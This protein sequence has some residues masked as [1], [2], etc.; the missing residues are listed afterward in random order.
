[1]IKSFRHK[2]LEEFFRNG[3]KKGI[4]PDHSSKLSRLLDRLDASLTVKDMAL[5]GFKLH[6]LSGK[7]KNI[8]S[9]WVNGNWRV[10]FYFEEGD[11]FIVDY[12]DY[13]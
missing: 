10:T 3:N 1:M 4:I 8:W 7:E 13:H 5:P 2:G 6:K 11:A 9:V 12:R